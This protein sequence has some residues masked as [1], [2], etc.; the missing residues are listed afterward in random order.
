MAYQNLADMFR[1]RAADF[2]GKPRYR[3]KRDGRWVEVSWDD[4]ARAVEE[5]A[6]GLIAAGVAP[7]AKVALLS[8]TRPEWMEIDFGILAAGGV[9]IPIYP[10]NLPDECGYILWNS[11]S[12]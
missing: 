8:G 10:S 2:A 11:E 9:T 1:R 6:A 7:G 3:V 4:H 5:I 12:S